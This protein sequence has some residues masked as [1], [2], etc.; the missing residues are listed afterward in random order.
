METADR[1]R[2]QLIE[3]LNEQRS[4]TDGIQDY[5]MRYDRAHRH[6]FANAACLRVSGKTAE[7]CIGKTHRELGYRFWRDS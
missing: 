7:E 5:V 2:A 6:T 3:G 1:T 4:V